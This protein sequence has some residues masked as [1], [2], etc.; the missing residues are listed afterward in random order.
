M[1]TDLTFLNGHSGAIWG[2]NALHWFGY[3]FPHDF[4]EECWKDSPEMARHLRG[5][6]NFFVEKDDS[7]GGFYRFMQALDQ[8]NRYRLMNYIIK[9]VANFKI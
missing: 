4:I 5:K 6:F 2:A 8:G 1:E 3:N 9:Y 7:L